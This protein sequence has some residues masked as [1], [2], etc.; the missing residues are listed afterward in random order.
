MENI[1]AFV[2]MKTSGHM[3]II[4]NAINDSGVLGP[5]K[6]DW[7]LQSGKTILFII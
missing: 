5:M 3:R 2:D 4:L 6:S 1:S 7:G